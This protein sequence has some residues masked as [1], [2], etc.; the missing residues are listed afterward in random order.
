MTETDYIDKKEVVKLLRKLEY[1][2]I[3]VPADGC[4]GSIVIINDTTEEIL[5]YVNAGLLQ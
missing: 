3:D 2:V 4:N 1:R 5:H